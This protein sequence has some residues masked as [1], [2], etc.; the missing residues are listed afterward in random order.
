MSILRCG[1]AMNV[2]DFIGESVDK[3]VKYKSFIICHSPYFRSDILRR[4]PDISDTSD[5]SDPVI[6]YDYIYPVSLLRLSLSAPTPSLN[7]NS[8]V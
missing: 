3:T 6:S 1:C 8:L 7:Q 4:I 5:N 2:F